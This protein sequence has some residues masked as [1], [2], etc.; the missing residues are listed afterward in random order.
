MDRPTTKEVARFFDKVQI[1]KHCWLWLASK[2]PPRYGYGRLKYHGKM[3]KAHRFSYEL[4]T[5]PIK[6]G[7][8]ILHRKE[9]GN[10]SCVNPNHLYMGTHFD[11]MRDRNIWGKTTKGEGNCNSRLSKEDILLIRKIHK[12]RLFGYKNT[13]KIVGVSA[14]M[15]GKIARGLNWPHII[16]QGE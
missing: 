16:T 8:M 5:G 6:P 9:C 4:F 12:D 3:I 7:M 15:V 1:T 10:P 13:A 2:F 14:D 11:N